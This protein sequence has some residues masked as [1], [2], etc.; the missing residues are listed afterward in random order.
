MYTMYNPQNLHECEEE[1]LRIP[2]H[3]KRITRRVVDSAMT[4]V[5]LVASVSSVP[6]VIKIWQT[7][8]VAGISLATYL[9][10]LGAVVAWFLYSLYIK[11]KPLL[12]TSFVSTVVL[13]VVV[14]QILLYV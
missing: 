14:V 6:Q 12:I 3:K 10:A 7:G 4:A 1:K 5:G 9:I 11:N 8:E 13:S 2:A